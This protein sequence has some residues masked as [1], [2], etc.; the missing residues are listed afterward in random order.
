M[1]SGSEGNVIDFNMT[2]ISDNVLSSCCTI[3]ISSQLKH[4]LGQMVDGAAP[5]FAVGV[6]KLCVL[7]STLRLSK[8]T[9]YDGTTSQA[10][11]FKY[12]KYGAGTHDSPKR[13]I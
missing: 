7:P 11:H 12:C 2:N 9:S 4:A 13:N 6:T 3:G 10:A 8:I 5:Y 1:S